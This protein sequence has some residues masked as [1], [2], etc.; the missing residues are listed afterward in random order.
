MRSA[1]VLVL[2]S[3][4]SVTACSLKSDDPPKELKKSS[5]SPLEKMNGSY[6]AFSDGKKLELFIAFINDG[7]LLLRDGD[8]VSVDVNGTAV[9]LT[10]RI[11]GDRVHYIGELAS[12]PAEPVVNVTFTRGAEKVVGTVRIA[13]S[14][15]LKSPQS[16]AK[17]G[18][19]VP[20]DIE[21][22]PNLDEWKGALGPLIHHVVEVHGECIDDEK[23]KKIELCAPDSA[24]GTCK[25][26]Y[27]LQWDTSKILLKDG[28][29]GCEVDVQVRLETGAPPGEGKFGGGVFEGLQHRRFKLALTK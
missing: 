16:S 29:S 25:I 8:N 9:P 4:I 21:P 19:M 3:G 14:F 6:G 27:P 11:E 15:E 7:F 2:L 23:Q 18:D 24:A 10:E 12:P 28:A 22:R 13:P 26:E 20:I 1:L 5:A 17:H